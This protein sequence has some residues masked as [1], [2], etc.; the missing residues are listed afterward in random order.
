MNF[1]LLNAAD[2]TL[3]ETFL[4]D[5][6]DTSMFLRSNIRR[7]GL[8]FQPEAFHATY[9]GAIRDGRITGVVAHSWNGMILVQA[10]EATGELAQ[11]CVKLSARHVTGLTGPL[12]QVNRV[13]FALNLTSTP[14]AMES[15][16]WLYGLDL[17][18]LR[19][20]DALSSGI[21][22]CRHPVEQECVTLREWRFNYAI[23][24]LGAA[25]SDETRRR[26]AHYLDLQIAERNAWVAIDNSRPVSLSSFN[27][28]LPDIVQLGGIYTPPDLR[29]RGYAKAAV[30]GSLI[31][32]RERGASRAVLFTNNPSAARSY[33]AVGFR[34][35]GDY[36]L[37]LLK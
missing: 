26:S 18:E 10:P 31:A 16:E 2:E 8:T 22:V 19:I 24:T 7:A 35:V 11:E 29:G 32:A 14:V 30:A 6:R 37:V 25:A 17:S 27:A 3:L 1:R 9:V 36:G 33:E 15:D 5:H 28:T 21:L 13:R 4:A 34:R 12:E 23:E 20:P